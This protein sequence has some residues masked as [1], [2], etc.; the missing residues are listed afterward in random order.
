MSERVRVAVSGGV[1][2]EEAREMAE[3]M[4]REGM[5]LVEVLQ[6]GNDKLLRHA[7]VMGWLRGW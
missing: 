5:D 7:E 3:Q 6:P 2:G 1:L 4:R